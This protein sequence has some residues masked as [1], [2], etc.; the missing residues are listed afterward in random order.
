MTSFSSVGPRQRHVAVFWVCVWASAC[1][2]PALE[3]DTL[4][5][6]ADTDSQADL[7]D[8]AEVLE[9]PRDLS[10][11]DDL[12]DRVR[13]LWSPVVGAD[14]YHVYR[15]GQRL[16]VDSGL[17]IT[18]YDDLQAPVVE[19]AWAA[20]DSLEASSTLT[21]RIEVT[22]RSPSRPLGPE[23][24]YQVVA[25]KNGVEGPSS[26]AVGRRAAR[27]IERFEVE[28]ATTDDGPTWMD[29]ASLDTTWAHR[30]APKGRLMLGGLDA[31]HGDFV[32]RVGLR[33]QDVGLVAAGAVTYRVKGVLQGGGDT[34]VS[35]ATV[36]Q[37]AVGKVT[38]DWRWASSSTG[39]FTS[40]GQSQE[41]EYD[42]NAPPN[43]GSAR[44]YRVEVRADGVDSQVS[45]IARGWRLFFAGL[46]MGA[47]FVCGTTLLEPDDG[48]VWCW[49][50]NEAGQLG[51][52]SIGG[53]RGPQRI[54]GLSSVTK[55]SAAVRNVCALDTAGNVT[56]WG[57]LGRLFEG[58]TTSPQRIEAIADAS[59]I[60]LVGS[61]V[62]CASTVTGVLCWGQDALGYG[63]LGDGTT[64][65]TR[66]TPA[67]VVD[68][69]SNP[70]PTL[71]FAHGGPGYHFCGR[72]GSDV[73]CWGRNGHMQLGPDAQGAS[74][75]H[76]V[77]I[78]I[79]RGLPRSVAVGFATT[80]GLWDIGVYC[81]GAP[82]DEGPNVS[83]PKL[84]DSG[85]DWL[86]V[87]GGFGHFCLLGPSGVRCV[88]ENQTGQL[89]TG[90]IQPEATWTAV[91]NLVAPTALAVGNGASCAIEGGVPWCWGYNDNQ[92]LQVSASET[93]VLEP[94][95]VLLP[96]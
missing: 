63:L 54:E 49:G 2:P 94:S 71:T 65:T 7:A 4:D 93:F 13:L 68:G 19:G 18:T 55:V 88:G 40:L 12:D 95:R 52:S 29:T 56:C 20:P 73:Y 36:G 5:T 79:D 58:N 66:L 44:Y 92:I 24:T 70:L 50:G 38:F 48:R 11:S 27:P 86:T 37:R 10:A 89:G 32:S 47:N 23:V 41:P 57:Q 77:K 16:T 67:E 72:H 76:A 87:H 96:E 31:S 8:G 42:D 51:L 26:T 62:A 61:T 78:S 60:S 59:D 3:R 46:T 39:V 43:D 53:V 9:A 80:C 22:W 34:P 17:T 91:R 85:R 90:S 45:D 75:S 64:G 28:V 69:S 25:L 81:W 82:F 83:T 6:A 33:A 14:A 1:F 21:D 30:D 84:S 15:D 74:S 35:Q